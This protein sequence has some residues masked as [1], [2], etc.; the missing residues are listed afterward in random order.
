MKNEKEMTL[1]EKWESLTL[2]DNFV[3]CKVMSANLDLCQ[4]LLETLLHIKID[5]LK[6]VNAEQTMQETFDAHGVR[7]DVYAKDDNRIFDIE[8]QTT[9]KKNL[10]KRARYYQSVIDIDNLPA[11]S[12]YDR[13]K[14]TYIIFLCLEDTFGQDLPVYTF[15][16]VC[17]E[18]NTLK[19]GD[20]CH[21]IFFNA[22][23][24]DKL[25]D[26]KTKSFFNL[27]NGTGSDSDFASRICE[28]VSYFKQN[29]DSRRQ[30]MVWALAI[31]EEKQ[32]AREEAR[33]QAREEFLAEGKTEAAHDTAVR[34]LKDNVSPELISKWTG[35]S[36]EEIQSLR[37]N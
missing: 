32:L 23:A 36:A 2:A 29:L 28:R 26:E 22:A 13:L 5:H 18:N 25:F 33:E 35:L 16:T 21:K 1:A 19:F 17:M 11:G 6:L 14:E 20:G 37:E 3:F 34:M 7:L 30:Y 10:V 8:I 4:E 24:C 12:D 9:R 27:L 31:E 15:E